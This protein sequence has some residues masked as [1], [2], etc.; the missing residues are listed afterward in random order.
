MK[1]KK[2][3]GI[4]KH[5]GCALVKQNPCVWLNVNLGGRKTSHMHRCGTG[6]RMNQTTFKMKIK[7]KDACRSLLLVQWLSLFAI[8]LGT[9]GHR[10]QT[11]GQISRGKHL[12]TDCFEFWKSTGRLHVLDNACVYL[13][14]AIPSHPAEKSQANPALCTSELRSRALSTLDTLSFTP[15]DIQGKKGREKKI[16]SLPKRHSRQG[17]WVFH[18]S[19]LSAFSFIRSMF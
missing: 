5:F 4:F 12:K 18:F 8:N 14:S 7:I 13:H 19:P 17:R 15:T 9:P 16:L 10:Q 2:K 3:Q 6:N 11:S 1:A